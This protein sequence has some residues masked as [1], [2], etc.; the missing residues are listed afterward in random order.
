MKPFLRLERAGVKGTAASLLCRIGSLFRLGT[1]L[2]P[3]GWRGAGL[4]AALWLLWSSQTGHAQTNGIQSQIPA[5]E[6]NALIDFYNST[7]G[8][9]WID[10]TG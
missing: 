6:Y 5:V 10:N 2:R 8:S 7:D 4:A 1:P 9:S 3:R